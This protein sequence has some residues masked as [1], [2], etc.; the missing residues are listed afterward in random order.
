MARY[1]AN[2][3]HAPDWYINIKT[4]EW[5]TNPPVTV[6]S[7][8]AFVAH[9]LGRRMAYTYEVVDLIPG[10]RLVMRSAEGP[11]PME[12]SDSPNGWP[13]SWLVQCDGRIA[14]TSPRSS[15]GSNRPT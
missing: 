1:A 11:F 4:V 3:D 2:P 6:G 12:T 7:Q 15:T 10:E 5:K 13:L 8:I 14:K 9:F